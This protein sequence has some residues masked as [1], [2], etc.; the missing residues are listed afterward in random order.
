MGLI[1]ADAQIRIEKLA[2]GGSGVG[3]INGK[4][5]FVPYSCP[6]DEL[7]VRVT[8]EKRSYLTAAIVDITTPAV[9]RVFPP[10]QLFGSCGGC[11]WQHV[12]YLRQLAEKRQIFAD[13]LWRGARVP[14]ECIAEVVPSPSPYGYRSR[15]QLK[16][17]MADGKL[18][19]G[20]Y[21]QGTHVVEDAR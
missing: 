20:F 14:A 10:C 2:F 21:R 15:V 3:R 6:G 17:H 16:L 1:V 7:I 5:C 13:A 11:S 9:D 4:V 12:D 19:I 18:Q 8:A